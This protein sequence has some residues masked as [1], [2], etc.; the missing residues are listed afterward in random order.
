MAHDVRNPLAAIKGAAQFLQ[1][2]AAAGTDTSRFL[3]IIVAQADRLDRTIADYQRIGRTEPV[4]KPVKLDALVADVLSSQT[5][6]APA[7]VTL[8]RALSAGETQCPLDADLLSAALENLVR[9]A[10]EAMGAAGSVTVLTERPG[11]D[12]GFAWL[13]V[14]DTGPGMN[15]R[16]AAQ[17][18]GDFFT[19]K[20][21]GSGLGLAFVRRV[22]EAH[23][24]DA[25]IKS[26][27][28]K[29]T[30]VRLRLPVS[31]PPA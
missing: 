15:P 25:T 4:L 16:H 17:A 30:T 5:L 26:A 14:T 3:G 9:N 29:G 21:T 7:G 6:A 23:G 18:F 22:A 19:T 13:S 10:F 20:T 31:V 27:E 2:E 28:G 24:G 11:S 12:P 8:D 1:G